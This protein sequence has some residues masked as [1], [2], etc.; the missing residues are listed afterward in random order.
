MTTTEFLL[1]LS[2]NEIS[3]RVN[4][5]EEKLGLQPKANQELLVN[6]VPKPKTLKNKQ[7]K[8]A[9]RIRVN[10][11]VL[12]LFIKY[13]DKA[14]SSNELAE[15]IGCTGAAVR[16]TSAWKSCQ[17]QKT[18][19]GQQYSIRKGFKDKNGNITAVT[20]ANEIDD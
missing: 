4:K 18:E 6:S 8:G 20:E 13:P 5:I 9:K 1:L 2:F 15:K 17:K 12:E 16:K 11:Q 7:T 10:T 3:L 19:A 14:W